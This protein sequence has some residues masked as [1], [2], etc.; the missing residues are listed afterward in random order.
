MES[1]P[2]A[3]GFPFSNV[4]EVGVLLLFHRQ[5]FHGIVTPKVSQNVVKLLGCPCIFILSKIHGAKF[6]TILGQIGDD[7]MNGDD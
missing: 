6:C 7:T 1:G 2:W 4:G 3:T 5:C